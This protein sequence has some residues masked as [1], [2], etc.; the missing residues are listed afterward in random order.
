MSERPDYQEPVP[1][2]AEYP[3]DEDHD[4]IPEGSDELVDPLEDDEEDD[5]LVESDDE[6]EDEED[7]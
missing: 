2:D 3:A 6:E 7:R 4:D 5:D 1:D